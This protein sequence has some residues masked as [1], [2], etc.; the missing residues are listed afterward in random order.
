MG[1]W[2]REAVRSL[3]NQV[4]QDLNG[5][6]RYWA[7][8]EDEF[9]E[10]ASLQFSGFVCPRVA[11]ERHPDPL[12]VAF[13]NSLF[14]EWLLFEWPLGGEVMGE[15]LAV[16]VADDG[17][18]EVG[19]MSG[20]DVARMHIASMAQASGVPVQVTDAG[21]QAWA[22]GAGGDGGAPGAP[23]NACRPDGD[24]CSEGGTVTVHMVEATGAEREE[25][26]C[27][28]HPREAGRT[29]LQV[30]QELAGEI[31]SPGTQER[32]AQ[33][34][35]TQFFGKFVIQDKDP[36][37]DV[38][39]LRDRHTAERYDV[40]DRAVCETDRW[41]EG[42]LAMRIA[43]VDGIW[44]NVGGSRLYD[45]APAGSTAHD[46][47]GE[48][49]PEDRD[50]LPEAEHAGLFLRLVRD[51]FGADGRYSDTMRPAELGA[52]RPGAPFHRRG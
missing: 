13:C 27:A 41:R 31:A 25:D 17:T 30:Y 22:R 37:R 46:G 45:V 18:V 44:L 26:A 43:C 21:R 12:E 39:V 4:N 34:E 5:M 3:V 49:H 40:V 16:K 36:A 24:A 38:V 8:R 32:L 7:G 23:D 50:V 15:R 42:T 10:D 47:P 51:C 19:V 9:I 35:K 29:P 14:T 2:D 48:V 11:Y 6:A 28:F 33:I 52:S 20:P 1:T